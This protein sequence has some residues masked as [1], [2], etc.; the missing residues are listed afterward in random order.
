MHW[1]S[2]IKFLEYHALSVEDSS[3]E[4]FLKYAE[5]NS[6]MSSLKDHL[7]TIRSR[8]EQ[9]KYFELDNYTQRMLETIQRRCR[10][11]VDNKSRKKALPIDMNAMATLT[12]WRH[13]K[14]ALLWLHLGCRKSSFLSIQQSDVPTRKHV[15]E[16][17]LS[18]APFMELVCSQDKTKEFNKYIPTVV[19]EQVTRD[20]SFPIFPVTPQDITDI[21]KQFGDSYSSHGFRRATALTIRLYFVETKHW[22]SIEHYD[23]EVIQRIELMY[24][25]ANAKEFFEYSVDW[26][27]YRYRNWTLNTVILKYLADGNDSAKQYHMNYCLHKTKL[28]QLQQEYLSLEQHPFLPVIGKVDIRD[29]YYQF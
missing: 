15:L 1:K 25:W 12:N 21:L 20:L 14:L 2:W 16:Q 5:L 7:S 9:K 11:F 26:K 17:T 23:N 22:F 19:W 8:C 4:L 24:A 6:D 3:L 10:Y 27:A 28:Y 13:Q 29:A 18:S